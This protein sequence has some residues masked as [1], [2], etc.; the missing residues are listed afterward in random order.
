MKGGGGLSIIRAIYI[1]LC[2][3][4]AAVFHTKMGIQDIMQV[5]WEGRSPLVTPEGCLVSYHVVN[6]E[7]AA[8]R[9]GGEGQSA[10][11]HQQRLHHQF[12]QNV[13]DTALREEW[14]ERYP[15]GV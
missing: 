7:D 6:L 2:V 3:F 11:R 8:D 15:R 10:D 4:S 12:L 5:E 1:V 13:G 9:L 14:G